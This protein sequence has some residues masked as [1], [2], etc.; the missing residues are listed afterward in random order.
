M[1]RSQSI[2]ALS[3][4]RLLSYAKNL[5]AEERAVTAKLLRHLLEIDKRLLFA[6]LGYSSLFHYVTE[7]LGFC[8]ASAQARIASMRLIAIVPEIE[9]KI[10][11][12]S[13]SLTNLAQAQRFFNHEQKENRQSYSVA[14]KKQ[15]IQKLEGKSTR[16][17]EKELMSLSSNPASFARPDQVRPVTPTLSEIRFIA[18]QE[19]LDQLDEIRGLLAH[20]NAHLS[21]AEL[22]GR[23][24]AITLEKLRAARFATLKRE[25]AQTKAPMMLC[26]DFQKPAS[27]KSSTTSRAKAEQNNSAP[28]E[29]IQKLPTLTQALQTVQRSIEP[30]L[31]NSQSKKPVI[32]VAA[33]SEQK[34]ALL[35][36]QKDPAL[37]S[38]K[39]LKPYQPRQRPS[40]PRTIQRSV[41][42]RD[43][44]ECCYKDPITG[45]KCGSKFALELDY[46]IPFAKGGR[47]SI[48]N[49]ITKCAT[50]NAWAATEEFGQQKMQA[51]RSRH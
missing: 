4:D 50:H 34:N 47:S 43:N 23:M 22:M 38:L 26:D 16:D 12:G 1:N 45:R 30:E 29:P 25:R 41:F 49:L 42:A 35:A 3:D 14:E 31:K 8:A 48:E 46:R 21:L 44:Y 24:A 2:E 28:K 18:D 39:I 19:L 37:K 9:E 32:Q 27:L 11:A 7:E 6:K 15:V 13:V 10:V 5:A 33:L 40:I 20:R 17:A 36:P 51:H